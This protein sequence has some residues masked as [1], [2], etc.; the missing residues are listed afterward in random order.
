MRAVITTAVFTVLIALGVVVALWLL[1]L[2]WKAAASSSRD[3]A[4]EEELVAVAERDAKSQVYY[5]VVE[6]ES[7]EFTLAQIAYGEID[8]AQFTAV[9]QSV[10][11]DETSFDTIA[12]LGPNAVGLGGEESEGGIYGSGIGLVT[13]TA[14]ATSLDEATALIDRLDAVPGLANVRYDTEA[15][16]LDGADAYYGVTGKATLTGTLLTHRLIPESTLSDLSNVVA[17]GVVV[18]SPSASPTPSATSEEG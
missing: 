9:I 3:S 18:P 11:N 5:D 6:R 16:Q 2:G 13:F 15:Y 4:A 12:I 7:E 10:A 17:P 14:R 1:A 8:Q